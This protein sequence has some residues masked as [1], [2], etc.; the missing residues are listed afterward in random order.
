MDLKY[1]MLNKTLQIILLSML[2]VQI[3]SAESASIKTLREFVQNFT[4]FSANFSQTQPDESTFSLNES[5]GYM[6]IERPGKLYWIYQ[7]PEHQE[8]ITDGKNLWIY[9]EDLDQATVRALLSVQA[10]FPMRWLIYNEP[11]EN[12]FDVIVGEKN[13]GISWFNLT[14]KNNTFFN[15]LDVAIKGNQL[16]QIWMYQGSDNVTK[17]IFHDAKS[18]KDIDDTKFDFIPPNG[19]DI[20]GVPLK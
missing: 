11:V 7:T 5:K 17:I 12:N 15:S 10:D 18:G 1:K 19:I 8:I 9:E 4:S 13:S 14:P 20:I 6:A 16:V 3:A 2:S